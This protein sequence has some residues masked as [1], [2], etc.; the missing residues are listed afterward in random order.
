MQEERALRK[1]NLLKKLRTIERA[2]LRD[3]EAI[4]NGTLSLS[5]IAKLYGVS[6]SR[7]REIA[8]MLGVGRRE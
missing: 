8:R 7:V 3:K 1:K 2:L 6:Y 4:E 5:G